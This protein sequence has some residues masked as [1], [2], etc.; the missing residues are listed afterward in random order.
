MECI[1]TVLSPVTTGLAQILQISDARLEMVL[2]ILHSAYAYE[3]DQSLDDP[4]GPGHLAG[5]VADT[6]H[7]GMGRPESL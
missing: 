3:V 6:F 1:R 5:K 4:V 7:V 2:Y